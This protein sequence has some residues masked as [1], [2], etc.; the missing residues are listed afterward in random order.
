MAE[1]RARMARHKGQMNFQ[2]ER[3]F[4][5]PTRIYQW[6]PPIK[7][8]T[9]HLHSPSAPSRLRRPQPAPQLP[10]RTTSR[11]RP[12]AGRDCHRLRA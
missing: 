4:L 5:W 10:K 9:N 6:K 11:D 7:L 12:R 3:K 8:N 1:P 2:N